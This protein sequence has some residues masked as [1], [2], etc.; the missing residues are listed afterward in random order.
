MFSGSQKIFSGLWKCFTY[1]YLYLGEASIWK[2]SSL[3]WNIQFYWWKSRI[4]ESEIEDVDSEENMQTQTYMTR[5]TYNSPGLTA[6]RTCVRTRKIIAK[7]D[8]HVRTRNPATAWSAIEMIHKASHSH[9][10]HNASPVSLSH[11]QAEPQWLMIL[12]IG[13]KMA[14][15]Y[16]TPSETSSDER[17]V[18]SNCLPWKEAAAEQYLKPVDFL[19]FLYLNLYFSVPQPFF[20]IYAVPGHLEAVSRTLDLPVSFRKF[21]ST[22]GVRTSLRYHFI[23]H[24][25]TPNNFYTVR[26]RLAGS[27]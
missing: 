1:Y 25:N 3:Q 19:G 8:I 2:Q 13:A 27:K 23:W 18:P 16:N 26:H 12:I 20:S 6:S 11:V 10:L 9:L 4:F 14:Y 5:K 15:A 17:L 22:V 21:T 7:S 24:D